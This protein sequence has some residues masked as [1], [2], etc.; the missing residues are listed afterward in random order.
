VAV[1]ISLKTC[2]FVLAFVGGCVTV[3]TVRLC[4][5]SDSVLQHSVGGRYIRH[6]HSSPYRCFGV[7]PYLLVVIH[8][9]ALRRACWCTVIDVSALRRVYWNSYRSF[10]IIACLLVQLPTFR[11]YGVFTG[12]HRRFGVTLFLLVNCY[13]RFERS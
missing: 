7:T 6:R 8:V 10:G 2:V 9:S 1:L 12:R 4:S 3:L 11:R 5:V 13:R